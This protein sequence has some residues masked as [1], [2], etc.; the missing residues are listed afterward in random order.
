MARGRRYPRWIGDAMLFPPGSIIVVDLLFEDYVVNV[1]HPKPEPSG[2]TKNDTGGVAGQ[3][4]TES[5]FAFP[6]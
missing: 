1:C 2:Y 5:D 6:R 3:G 4:T